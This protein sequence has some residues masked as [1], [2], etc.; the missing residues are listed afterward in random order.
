MLL[1]L[2]LE[3]EDVARLLFERIDAADCAR[4][5]ATCAILGA[6]STLRRRR[7]RVAL[8][9][10]WNWRGSSEVVE[11]DTP[12]VLRKGRKVSPRVSAGVLN[13]GS[14]FCPFAF[15]KRAEQWLMRVDLVFDDD[16]HT[17]VSAWTRGAA[18][19]V[20]GPELLQRASM[21][22]APV[23]D[24]MGKRFGEQASRFF[25]ADAAVAFPD[26]C[27]SVTSTQFRR[28]AFYAARCRRCEEALEE[29][30]SSETNG[31]PAAQ[32]RFA[33]LQ[34]R[35]HAAR[36]AQLRNAAAQ[37]FRLQGTAVRVDEG[38]RENDIL[39]VTGVSAPFEVVA[40]EDS[41]SAAKRAAEDSARSL[42]DAKRARKIRDGRHLRPKSH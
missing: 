4:L 6:S 37:L 33:A 20:Y 12:V 38:A 16:E 18:P 17:P 14:R 23:R 2:C 24:W 34:E 39:H 19:L 35:L 21:V 42:R 25:A 40:R 13:S 7:P 8:C 41:A 29:A 36:G 3:H 31:S 5:R 9:L 30:R 27:I 15:S 1:L 10:N 11:D 32:A 28:A 22:G 26:F